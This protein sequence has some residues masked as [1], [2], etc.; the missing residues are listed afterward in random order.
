MSFGT[1][2]VNSLDCDDEYVSQFASWILSDSANLSP[3]FAVAGPSLRRVVLD[4]AA[5]LGDLR[6]ARIERGRIAR[7]R[8]QLDLAIDVDDEAGG[9]GDAE[10]LVERGDALAERDRAAADTSLSRIGSSFLASACDAA[11]M[12]ATM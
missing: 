6:I 2:S 10:L 9:A 5:E 7:G 11:L 8:D 3:G 1:V 4:A 12:Y